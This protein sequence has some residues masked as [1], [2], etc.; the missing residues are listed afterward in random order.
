MIDIT[1]SQLNPVV[2]CIRDRI[3]RTSTTRAKTAAQR[4]GVCRRE[5]MFEWMTKA[6]P[7][8][9]KGVN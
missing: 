9:A 8:E 5:S 3:Q 4:E 1:F 6:A 7:S 2:I